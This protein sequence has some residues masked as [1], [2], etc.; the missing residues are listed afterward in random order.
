MVYVILAN[1]FEE[2]EALTPVDVLK[3]GG[4]DVVTVGITGKCAMGA[5]GIPV[6]CDVTAEELGDSLKD[7]ELLIFPGGMPGA[8]NID[9]FGK[10]DL[11]IK[12]VLD[13]D[14][15]VGAICAAPLVLGRRGY[16]KGK[17]AVCFPG[18]EGYLEGADVQSDAEVVRDGQF[19]T[20]RCMG[21][22]MAFA[23]ELLECLRGKETRDKTYAAI[24]AR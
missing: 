4:L 19:V 7:A 8:D 18:F 6:V 22:A 20:S 14:G 21:T 5:H 12:S 17:R 23:L 13:A 9:K 15:F 11:Y 3:R 10:T 24:M 1:D 2:I 16:L